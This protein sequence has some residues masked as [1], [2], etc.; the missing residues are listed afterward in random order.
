M[1]EETGEVEGY[2]HLCV[3]GIGPKCKRHEPDWHIVGTVQVATCLDCLRLYI[4]EL[5]ERVKGCLE[6]LIGQVKGCSPPP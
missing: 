3:N 1:F 5:E 6:T 2:I 4:T